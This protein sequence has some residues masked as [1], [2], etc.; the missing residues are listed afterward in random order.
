MKAIRAR[1]SGVLLSAVLVLVGTMFGASV[2]QRISLIPEW[3]GAL[4]QS[5]VAYFGD[6]R[7]GQAI[8]RFW[9]G[10][11]AP[12]AVAIL[13]ALAL[14]WTSAARRRW[15]GR[16]ALLFFVLLAWTVVF[17]IPQGVMPLMVRG[18]RG[19][20]P[21]AITEMARAWIFW[22]WFR[23]AGTLA[24][25]LCFVKAAAAQPVGGAIP[26]SHTL[27]RVRGIWAATASSFSWPVYPRLLVRMRR[28]LTAGR[29]S[30]SS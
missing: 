22:D 17:F 9:T 29:R 10:V 16:G 12:T 27:E 11:T 21:A 1:L 28:P 25:Y 7:A 3:G 30:R 23:M 20:T 24:A 15:I 5:V 26:H 18:G 4:P 14:N 2:Y 6:P 19:L 8:D 13:L